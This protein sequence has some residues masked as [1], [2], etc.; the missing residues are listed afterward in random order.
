ME[1]K[2]INERESLELITRMIADTRS[3]IETR[4]GNIVLNWGLLS[5]AVA[6]IVWIALVITGNPDFNGLWDLLP[7]DTSS[8]SKR[9]RR[10]GKK[11][12]RLSPIE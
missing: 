5:V 9:K 4:D 6:A 8:T 1:E 3:R 11:D 2:R 12:T 7:S 10:K